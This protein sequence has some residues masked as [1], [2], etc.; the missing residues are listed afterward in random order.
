MKGKRYLQMLV[1]AAAV[2]ATGC[3]QSDPS[4]A[5]D[6]DPH[7]WQRPAVLLL[8]NSDTIT[9]REVK[10]FLRCNDRF[11]EDTLT[12]RVET[13]TPDSM[14]V[15]EYLCIPFPRQTAPAALARENEAPYRTRIRFR[16][17]GD[18]RMILTPTRPVRGIE[19]VGVH[20]EA[21]P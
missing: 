1:L 7:G 20:I 8:P 21:T 19:A 13:V 9:L 11:S 4:Y 10:L 6:V 18:Y 3:T 16:Q 12:L 15:G 17:C 14:H 2:A 5:E